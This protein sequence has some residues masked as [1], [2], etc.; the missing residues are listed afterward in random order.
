V[1]V[2]APIPCLDLT[3]AGDAADLPDRVAL[4]LDDF[5]P[6]AIHE[7]GDALTP[8]WRVFLSDP[9]ATARAAELLTSR[10]ADD[11]LQI[12]RAE[13]P[14]EDWAARTQAHLTRIT[15]GEVIVAPPWDT[16]PAGSATV[17]TIF[18]STGFGTGHHQTTRLC[19]GLLQ[20]V[21]LGG[22]RVVDLGTG[23]GVL[24]LAAWRLGAMEVEGIDYEA[25]ALDNARENL[26]LNG[27]GEA[28]TLRL[29]DLRVERV[30]PAD[31]VVANLTGALLVSLAPAITDLVQP[32][33]TLVV[34]GF[35][36][37]EVDALRAVFEPVLTRTGEIGE[38]AWR[39]LRFDRAPLSHA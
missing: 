5:A 14:D 2:P 31:L 23:S 29:A 19:L 18:P 32:G 12:A 30:A 9:A 3:F 17:I 4:A 13:V 8:V 26:R 35:M 28:I 21:P 6:A 27:A 1:T 24:A 20:Q 39:A 34:S 38:D 37:P 16:P 25:D 15:V 36:A 22:R 10:F 33:G 11:G 7:T